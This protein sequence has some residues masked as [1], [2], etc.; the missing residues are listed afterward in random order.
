MFALIAVE[1]HGNKRAKSRA[2]AKGLT[3]IMPITARTR[4]CRRLY[5]PEHNIKC[6]TSLLSMMVHY[7]ER[8][9]HKYFRDHRKPEKLN[10]AETVDLSL[11]GYNWGMGKVHKLL[12]RTGFRTLP[13]LWGFI[14]P[15]TKAYI[16]AVRSVY[17]NL[18]DRGI[19]DAE[20]TKDFLKK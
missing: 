9:Y 1:S 5:N 16:L 19:V 3:G 14:R 15:Q 2:G 7:Y 6:G 12:K 4:K 11:M 18:L 17:R 20:T 8:R 13:K 10:H